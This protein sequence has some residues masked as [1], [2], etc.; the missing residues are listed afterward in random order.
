MSCI[1][2]WLKVLGP[3]LLAIVVAVATWRFQ[4]WQVRLAKQKLRHDLYDRRFAIYAAFR[5]LLSVLIEKNNEEIMAA[6]RRASSARFEARFLLEDQI[7]QATLEALCR[8][9]DDDVISNIRYF[10]A[11][12]SPSTVNDPSMAPESI[13]RAARLSMAKLDIAGRYFEELPKQFGKSLKLTDF[14]KGPK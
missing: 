3:F 13:Q 14:W 1:L 2:E 11:M 5:E 10:D 8:E 6:F 12:K 4:E 7:I 9:V